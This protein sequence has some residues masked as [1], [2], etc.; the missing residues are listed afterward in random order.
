MRD[1]MET[2]LR[3]KYLNIEDMSHHSRSYTD[4]QHL[5]E[6][7]SLKT[8]LES[9]NK[10]FLT[11]IGKMQAENK[12][13]KQEID[14]LQDREIL[15]YEKAEKERA[16]KDQ[17]N[18]LKDKVQALN[19]E[20]DLERIKVRTMH[21]SEEELKTVIA[22]LRRQIDTERK[23]GEDVETYR[24]LVNRVQSQNRELQQEI[25]RVKSVSKQQ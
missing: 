25:E 8:Q 22:D 9:E 1:A 15:F 5:R 19:R 2:S 18:E 14:R 3:S 21:S 23:S 13:L 10:T 11:Q 24:N 6:L 16:L 20:I 17:V 4:Q 12:V 7:E